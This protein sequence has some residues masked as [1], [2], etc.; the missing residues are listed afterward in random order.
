MTEGGFLNTLYNLMILVMLSVLVI[1]SIIT[2]DDI[3]KYVLNIESVNYLALVKEAYIFTL[4]NGI[5]LAAVCFMC[6]IIISK[7]KT[8]IDESTAE[9]LRRQIIEPYLLSGEQAVDMMKDG[10]EL[11]AESADEGVFVKL[12]N[13]NDGVLVQRLSDNLKYL[14]KLKN[15]KG[16]S[17]EELRELQ[18]TSNLKFYY[19]EAYNDMIDSGFSFIQG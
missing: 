9:C 15:G 4:S 1:L 7:M 2:T 6:N 11:Y 17:E 19:T 12:I 14:I 16:M 8:D 18:S 3:L 10:Q 5:L 13:R